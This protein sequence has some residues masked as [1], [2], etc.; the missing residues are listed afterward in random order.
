MSRCREFT[1]RVLDK[2]HGEETAISEHGRLLEC[3]P[4]LQM[5]WF[6]QWR[7]TVCGIDG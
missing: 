1:R 6:A 2:A 4:E 5:G 3:I 7:L